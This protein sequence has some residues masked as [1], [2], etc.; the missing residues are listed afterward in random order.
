MVEKVMGRNHGMII[1]GRDVD[2]ATVLQIGMEIAIIKAKEKD[3]AAK[4]VVKKS[5]IGG[6]TN[7]HRTRR[8][9]IVFQWGRDME[10]RM[11][12]MPTEIA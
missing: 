4:I 7:V 10:D 6:I 2:S 12:M 1:A 11:T 9:T 8:Q 3:T 5:S